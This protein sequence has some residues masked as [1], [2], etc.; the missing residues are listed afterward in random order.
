MLSDWTAELRSLV[1]E[2][3]GDGVMVAFWLPA[4]LAEKLA[5]KGGEDPKD[6]HLTV[7]FLGNTKDL[8]KGGVKTAG[9]VCKDVARRFEPLNARLGGLGRF[10]ASDT[11]DGKDVLYASVDSPRLELVRLALLQGFQ[12]AGIE[13]PRAHGYTPHITLA[14]IS[15][16]DS[17]PV[18]RI[19]ARQFKL[20]K[21]VLAVGGERQTFSLSGQK[22][23]TGGASE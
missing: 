5:V 21:L 6:L 15:P 11:S 18:N 22:I 13:W 4:D 19:R 12:K 20:D 17:L 9:Q 3:K 7:C 16:E 23:L 14:Y 10:A 2:Y 1:E 8:G